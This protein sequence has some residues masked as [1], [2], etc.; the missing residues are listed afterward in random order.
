MGEVVRPLSYSTIADYEAQYDQA[1]SEV[2][3]QALGN[4]RNGSQI[5]EVTQY[6]LQ[7]DLKG[8]RNSLDELEQ[9]VLAHVPP[10]S[11]DRKQLIEWI[12][13]TDD[14]DGALTPIGG[15]TFLVAQN[16]REEGI[17]LVWDEE[18]STLL[19]AQILRQVEKEADE[20]GCRR[21]LHIY[22][23]ACSVN[24]N[25]RRWQFCSIPSEQK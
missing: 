21:P 15:Y 10:Q 8:L 13:Q 5:D 22:A 23:C 1:T 6:E 7:Q 25:S 4:M 2:E 20:A 24:S 16:K 3:R 11:P 17:C 19:T 14:S 18:E 9:L 12:C